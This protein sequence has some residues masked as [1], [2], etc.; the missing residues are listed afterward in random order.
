MNTDEAWARC[1]EREGKGGQKETVQGSRQ[2]QE[3]GPLRGVREALVWPEKHVLYLIPPSSFEAN[4]KD[5]PSPSRFLLP[6]TISEVRHPR[7]R[8]PLLK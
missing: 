7:L 8:H 6:T 3:T 5:H 1:R 2:V 4:L